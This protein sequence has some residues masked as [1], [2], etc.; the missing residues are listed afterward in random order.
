MPCTIL[1][2]Y[3]NWCGHC[4][5]MAPEWEQM[6]SLMDTRRNKPEIFEIES[7]ELNKLEE[8]NN[9]RK[10]NVTYKGFPTIVKVK[11]GVVSYYNGPRTSQEMF[12]WAMKG[13]NKKSRMRK[14]NKKSKKKRS[15]RSTRKN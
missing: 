1:K 8:F 3:A 15:K 6:K 4:I 11:N 12:K 10:T 2:I 7:Q 5:R 13:E 14:S 9:Q